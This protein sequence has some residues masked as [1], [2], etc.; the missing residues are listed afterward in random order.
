MPYLERVAKDKCV[1]KTLI[2]G[3][4]PGRTHILLEHRDFAKKVTRPNVGETS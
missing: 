2:A 1:A 3:I 4:I